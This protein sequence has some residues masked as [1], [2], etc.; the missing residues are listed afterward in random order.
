MPKVKAK[1]SSSTDC[2]VLFHRQVTETCSTCHR[3]AVRREEELLR[4]QVPFFHALRERLV[5]YK[6][7]G[8]ELS[9]TKVHVIV[10][11]SMI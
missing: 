9:W 1:G 7:A 5:K 10:W 3:M 2:V 8:E 4:Q 11:D 6:Q